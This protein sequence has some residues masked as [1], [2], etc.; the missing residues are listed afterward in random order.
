MAF[1]KPFRRNYRP[2]LNCSD[3]RY[4]K[5]PDYALLPPEHYI[6]AF[7]LIQSDMKK[8][9]EYIEPSKESLKT[10]SYR[11][12]ELLLRTCI[13][14]E[15]NF[16]AI[17]K[18]NTFSTDEKKWNISYYKKINI[19]HHLDDYTVKIPIWAGSDRTFTPFADWKDKTENSLFWYKAYNESKHD[20]Q[21]NFKQAN[22]KN[23][24]N[25]IAGLFVLL[26]SQFRFEDFA[27]PA[28]SISR[29]ADQY[30]VPS[31]GIGNFFIIEFPHDWKDE[32]KYD[33]N[34]IELEK[35]DKRF[36]KINYDTILTNK[37][38]DST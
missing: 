24:V 10:Y 9:F 14:V 31:T 37:I 1:N 13:E 6:R 19:T 23:L 28:P 7:L 26:S 5:D 22:F 16:K 38:Q 32:E 33:F 27:P 12:H 4:I 20:R 25:A 11:I 30:I 29:T 36:E 17:F 2:N 18:D 35:E 3:E 21:K 15:A 8:M 34:W